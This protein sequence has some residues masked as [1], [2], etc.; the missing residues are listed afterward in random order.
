MLSAGRDLGHTKE[1]FRAALGHSGSSSIFELRRI[2]GRRPNIFRGS[3]MVRQSLASAAF[4]RHENKFSR[5]SSFAEVEQLFQ[6]PIEYKY[7]APR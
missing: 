5:R 1:D 6:N 4:G 3:S 7:S 2:I